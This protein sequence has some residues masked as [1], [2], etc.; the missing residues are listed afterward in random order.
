[1]T[2]ASP[3]EQRRLL[4][5]Q[6][7][8]NAI[9]QLRY[10]RAHLPEQQALD[11]RVDLME[12]LTTDH[13]A[14]RDEL[15]AVDRQQKRLEN[16][17]N[18]VDARRKAE[19]ARMYSGVI[20]SEREVEALRSE[21][22]T[23]KTRKRDLED[24]LLE[25]MERQEELTSTV[26]T[27]EARRGEVQAEIAPLEQARDVAAADID[28][29]LASRQAARAEL[30]HRLPDDLVRRYDELRARKNGVAVVELRDGTCQGC[31]LEIA[32]GELEEGRELGIHGLARCVQ[33]ERLLVEPVRG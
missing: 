4:E 30:A 12:Q 33:C 6:A 2:K 3:E 18:T 25:V 23:L 22:S 26:R 13:M 15:V 20:A 28:R 11:E 10:R 5:L 1:V 19:E 17:I 9:R 32:P 21:L 27:L 7:T 31:F 24:N 8:D 16:D 29:E 14:S